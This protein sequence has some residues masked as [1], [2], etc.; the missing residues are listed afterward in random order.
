METLGQNCVEINTSLHNE[1]QPDGM[2]D[3]VRIG[4]MKT[5]CWYAGVVELAPHLSPSEGQVLA[6]HASTWRDMPV[7][8]RSRLLSLLSVARPE[9]AS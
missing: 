1:R 7:I 3:L 4:R 8:L 5:I 2:C 6:I 9:I